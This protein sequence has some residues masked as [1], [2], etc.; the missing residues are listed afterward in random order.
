MQRLYHQSLVSQGLEPEAATRLIQETS[1]N[2]T[3]MAE[4]QIKIDHLLSAIREEENITVEDG[5]LER[6]MA[7]E[8][9]RTGMPLPR[10]KARYST[11]ESKMR[12]ES[13]VIRE[14]LIAFLL[15]EEFAP[16]EEGG[17]DAPEAADAPEEPIQAEAQPEEVETAEADTS[18]ETADDQEKKDD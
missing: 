13:R 17:D 9:Q 4:R 10:I 3:P 6:V 12:L 16:A 18:E 5:D 11:G 15:G 7:Q 2:A 1:A 8:S 14:K